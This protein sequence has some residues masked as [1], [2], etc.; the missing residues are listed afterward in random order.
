MV[1]RSTYPSITIPD[2]A[3]SQFVLGSHDAESA[4][5]ALIDGSTERVIT[6]AELRDEVRRIAGGLLR[7][8]VNRGDVVAVFG[9]S[10]PAYVATFY[11]VTA[12]GAVITSLNVIHNVAELSYQ[13]HR[14]RRA[15]AVCSRATRLR[16][17]SPPAAKPAI[18]RVIRLDEVRAAGA[19]GAA[20]DLS[21]WRRRNCEVA[22]ITYTNAPSDVPMG[23]MVTHR[24]LVA[25]LLQSQAVDPITSDEVVVG[26]MPFCQ[27]YGMVAVN[28]GTA[29]R[30]NGR[31]LPA[32]QPRVAVDRDG[33]APG[34]QRVSGSAGHPDAG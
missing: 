6:Y 11:G 34:Y 19:D 12:A 24:N 2:L 30:R 20:S 1:T 17:W 5:P 21:E 25:N 26:L 3:I 10:S 33:E 9:P 14:L 8:G 7:L 28:I 31:D 23:V 32:L 29:G 4:K 15:G 27:L 18:T 16:R 22:S 13:L